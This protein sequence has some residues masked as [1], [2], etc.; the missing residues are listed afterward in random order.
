MAM[1]HVIS[2]IQE[3]VENRLIGAFT[4]IE[5]ASDSTSC[6]IKKAAKPHGLR[7]TVPMDCL[8]AEL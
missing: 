4:D 5:G 1:H 3:A 8:C 2:H 7:D 6:D